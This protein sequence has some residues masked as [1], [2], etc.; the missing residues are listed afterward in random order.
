[1][2]EPRRRNRGAADLRRNDP[3]AVTQRLDRGAQRRG[4]V[5]E[6]VLPDVGFARD[7]EG[8]QLRELRATLERLGYAISRRTTLL[9]LERRLGLLAGEDAARYVRALRERRFARG[10]APGRAERRAL[11]RAL[12]AQSGALGRLRAG[13]A[14]RR[15]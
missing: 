15:V 11:R 5:A 12:A 6:E 8:E 14:L 3:A 2:H 13:I 9:G 7:P 4:L 10:D 1:V